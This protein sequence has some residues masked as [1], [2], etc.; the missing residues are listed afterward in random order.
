MKQYRTEQRQ[1][2]EAKR[3]AKAQGN[4]FVEGQPKVAVVTRIRGYGME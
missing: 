1:V 4:F 3:A 2:I